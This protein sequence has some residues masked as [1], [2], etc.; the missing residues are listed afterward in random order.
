MR[1]AVLQSQD[2]QERTGLS[3]AAGS[4]NGQ[5]SESSPVTDEQK[6]HDAKLRFSPR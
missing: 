5:S 6:G 2:K 1:A 3:V 4:A